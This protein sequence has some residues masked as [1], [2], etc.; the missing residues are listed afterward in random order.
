[1]WAKT[2]AARG[3][4]HPEM[5]QDVG[6]GAWPHEVGAQGCDA[7][8]G[9]FPNLGCGA[10]S[11]DLQKCPEVPT[12][13]WRSTEGEAEALVTTTSVSNDTAFVPLGITFLCP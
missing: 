4:G 10:G 7:D 13:A 5:G 1:M 12:P 2:W 11:G 9:C 8:V 3:S 6:L